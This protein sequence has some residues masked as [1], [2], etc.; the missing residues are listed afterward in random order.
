M[1]APLVRE[2]S[3]ENGTQVT[4]NRIYKGYLVRQRKLPDQADPISAREHSRLWLRRYG[5]PDDSVAVSNLGWRKLTFHLD[6]RCTM[7]LVWL[8][9]VVPITMRGG[10]IAKVQQRCYSSCNF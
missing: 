5:F 10:S 1:K 2:G 4:G 6:R 7:L 8:V 9:L 3:K